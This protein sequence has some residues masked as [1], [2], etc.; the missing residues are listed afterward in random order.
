MNTIAQESEWRT[1]PEPCVAASLERRIIATRWCA[2]TEGV[3]VAC[4]ETTPDSHVV[5]IVLRTMNIR[6]SVAGETVHDGAIPPG[7]FHLTGPATPV[8]CL[9][10]GSYDVLHLHVPDDL[11]SEYVGNVPNRHNAP[12]RMERPIRDHV[13]ERLAR[14]LLDGV[15][16]G[17]TA[18]RYTDCLNVAITARLVEL[19]RQRSALGRPKVSELPPWRLRRAIDYFEARLSEPVPLADVALVT[20]V[21]PMHFAAQFRAATGQSPHQYL[22]RRRI[23]RAVEML[24]GSDETL[25]GIALAVGFKTQSHFTTVF[26]RL[27]GRPPNAWRRG[28]AHRTVGM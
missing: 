10:R 8:K 25:A 11:I 12:F 26:K 23:D 17:P 21:T 6:L 14:A 22:L 9:F 5:K 18:Q 19:L 13:V 3:Q 16:S 24:M 1:L 4:A 27:T 2:I 20:G 15:I 7:T 28:R